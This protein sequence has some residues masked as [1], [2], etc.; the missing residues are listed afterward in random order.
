[1]REEGRLLRKFSESGSR[2]ARSSERSTMMSRFPPT[3]AVH[4]QSGKH[5]PLGS[6]PTLWSSEDE[7]GD[8][9]R[10]YFNQGDQVAF[11]ERRVC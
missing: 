10:L 1:M 2:Q 11:E 5:T 6:S 3:L 8:E 7:H 9:T 4:I